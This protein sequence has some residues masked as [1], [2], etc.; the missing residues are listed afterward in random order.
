[1]SELFT[2]Q[3]ILD[4]TGG[5]LLQGSA[6]TPVF[7]FAFDSR[8][9]SPGDG[10][11]ALEG[12]RVDGHDFAGA[13]VAAGAVCVI[14]GRPVAAGPAGAVVE[15][16]DP[17]QALGR[18]GRAHRLRFPVPLVAIT[19]S[20]GKTTTKEIIAAVLSRRFEVFRNPGNFNSEVGMPIGLMALGPA[21]QAAVQEMGMRAPGEIAYLVSIAR[22]DVG[23]VT[24]VGPTHLEL[25]GSIENIARA[26]SEL[27]RGLPPD[28]AAVLNADD[29]RVV[30]MAALAPARLWFYGFDA[31]GRGADWVSA[32]G[33]RREGEVGQRFTLL[34]SRGEAEAVLPAPGRHNVLNAMAA[35]AVGLQL[36][37]PLAEAAAGLADY[38]PQGSRMRIMTVGPL[39]ILD[40][41]YN[42]APASTIA[43]LGV[44]RELAGSG[45][46]IAVLGSMFELGAAAEDGHRQV[47]S[48]AARL[49]DAV[50][51]VGDL[52]A[53]IA[54]AAGRKGTHFPDKQGLAAALTALLQP[55]D[56]VLVKGSRGMAMEEIVNALE[57]H[58]HS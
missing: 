20:V 31:A 14:A 38:R 56:T 13:A 37:L 42:A 36:G 57:T 45:R 44:M 10:F 26:K 58:Y 21:H 19:G 15:V 9:V 23:V 29:Q 53:D 2:V 7:G 49:A 3:Q 52:A 18:L 43:A 39:R 12:E 48:E 47:G 24:N 33:L 1:M 32:R 55:G 28:G 16:P 40:D 11:V 8:R 25:L 5:R 41:T 6:A 35:V 54:A 4:L 34:T 50:L 46:C 17:L 27:L 22:P 51:T 30:A